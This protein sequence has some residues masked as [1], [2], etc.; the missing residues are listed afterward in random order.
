[1]KPSTHPN[2]GPVQGLSV[3]LPLQPKHPQQPPAHEGCSL[4]TRNGGLVCPGSSHHKA[5]AMC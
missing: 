3:S 1:M 2:W 4:I 5:T